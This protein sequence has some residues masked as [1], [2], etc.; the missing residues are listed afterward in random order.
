MGLGSV[1]VIVVV[2]VPLC[3]PSHGLW[4]A[5][6]VNGSWLSGI[7]LT[8]PLPLADYSPLTSMKIN[9][10]DNLL[11]RS[12]PREAGDDQARVGICDFVGECTDRHPSVHKR[13]PS[14]NWAPSGSTRTSLLTGTIPTELPSVEFLAVAVHGGQVVVPGRSNQ[15]CVC[16]DTSRIVHSVSGL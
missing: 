15:F 8:G 16:I 2:V 14:P 1:I 7:H 5:D 13:F 4:G 3:H 11:T 9:L 12:I 6:V 10:D